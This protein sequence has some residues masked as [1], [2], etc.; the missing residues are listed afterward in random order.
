M[1]SSKP[2]LGVND[3]QSQFPE[4]AAEAYG[5]DPATVTANSHKKKDWKCGLGHIY[6]SVVASRTTS[7]FG[8]NGC[9]VCYG[10]QVLAEYNDLKSQFPEI[11]AEAYGWDPA[12]VVAKTEQKKDWIC[13]L[14]HIYSSRVSKRVTQKRGCPICA[15]QQVLEG[16]NDLKTKFPEIAAEAYGWD[17][18]TITAHSS[19]K[20]DWKCGLGHIYT[21]VVASRTTNGNGCPICAGQ[22]VLEGFNDLKTKFPEIAAEAYGWDPAT[23]AAGTGRKAKWKCSLGH[24]WTA[25][26]N[27]RT[28]SGNGCPYCAEY[29]FKKDKDAWFYLMRRAGEQQLGITNDLKTRL[30]VHER[31]GWSL[32]EYVGSAPGSIVL[33]TEVSFKK[34]LKENIGVVEGTTENWSTTKMEVQSLAELKARSGIETDLF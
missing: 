31:N 15:G 12:T 7:R 1:P 23:V 4:I 33:E 20:Q 21:S 14:G 6:T 18:A 9:P 13:G 11:A 30:K 22:Q 16:F 29:G 2:V 17:P 25:T 28:N 26:I 8:G 27:S 24:T 34:W 10:R 32:I 19:K 3:L 5:W